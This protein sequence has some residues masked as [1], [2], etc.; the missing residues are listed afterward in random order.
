MAIPKASAQSW[1]RDTSILIFL[2]GRGKKRD[3]FRLTSKVTPKGILETYHY[4]ALLSKYLAFMRLC[5]VV[6]ACAAYFFFYI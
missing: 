3:S 1:R 6:S 4:H 5:K 2:N